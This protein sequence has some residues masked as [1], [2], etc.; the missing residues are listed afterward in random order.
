[1]TAALQGAADVAPELFLM[2]KTKCHGWRPDEE[3]KLA[4]ES[5]LF[6][7]IA[8]LIVEIST[9]VVFLLM[10]GFLLAEQLVQHSDH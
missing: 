3:H 5:F 4:L 6:S 10:I 7:P 1:M 2:R 8:S 9:S